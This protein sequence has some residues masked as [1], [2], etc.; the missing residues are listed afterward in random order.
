MLIGYARISRSGGAQSA[1]LQVD[2]LL[3]AGVDRQRI[4]RD[5]ISGAQ[6]ERP[7]LDEC[8]RSLRQ[9]DTLVVW[10]LDR[11]G[12]S[13]KHLLHTVEDLERRNIGFRSLT[14]GIDTTT[15]TGTLVFHILGALAQFERDLIR[16]RVNAGLQAARARGRLGG[17]PAVPVERLLAAAAAMKDETTSPREIAREFGIGLTTL[18]RHVAPDGSYRE[19]LRKR[20]E[21]RKKG[22]TRK[23]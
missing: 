17:R 7:G 11:L 1:D 18:Y 20:L 6:A 5:S 14:E 15:P 3:A 16:E 4:Y 8:L 9:G 10:R 12:R 23:R 21:A 19:P 2:A 22:K 13:L